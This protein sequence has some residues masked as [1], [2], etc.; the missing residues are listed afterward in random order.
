MKYLCA[1]WGSSIKKCETEDSITTEDFQLICGD[2]VKGMMTIDGCTTKLTPGFLVSVSEIIELVGN[3]DD[4]ICSPHQ[5]K[6]WYWMHRGRLKGPI[7]DEVL[8][9]G[10]MDFVW[11]AE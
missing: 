1:G 7:V 11:E 4:S 2:D 6:Y 5:S 3:L 10:P 9:F 8:D